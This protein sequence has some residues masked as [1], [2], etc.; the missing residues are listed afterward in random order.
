MTGWE[1]SAAIP[2]GT[3]SSTSGA[4]SIAPT[5]PVFAAE[6]V[7]ESVSSGYA[8]WEIPDPKVESNPPLW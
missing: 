1:R 8:I 5:Y 3:L 6:C 7:S 2:A 4:N